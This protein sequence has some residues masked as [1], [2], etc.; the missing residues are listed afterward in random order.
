MENNITTNFAG[1]IDLSALRKKRFTIDGDANRVLELDT[2]D[3]TILNRLNVA[4]P[5]LEALRDE[6]ATVDTTSTATEEAVKLAGEEL[7][8]VDSKMREIVDYIFDSNVSAICAPSGSMYDVFGGQMRY[9]IIINSLVNLYERNL[10][11]EAH[12]LQV[13]AQSHT[14]KYT[15]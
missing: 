12:R 5:K 4:L 3:M 9:E 13:R 8:K 14:D 7:S 11:E 1:N 10:S 15:K 2:S 6:L